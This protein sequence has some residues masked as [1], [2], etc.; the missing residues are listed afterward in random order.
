MSDDAAIPAPL[1]TK[2]PMTAKDVRVSAGT[3]GMVSLAVF[4]SRILGLVREIVFNSLFGGTMRRWG[5]A[6]TTA[7]RVP[8]LLRDLFA[9]GALSTAFVTT[10]S[11][12]LATDG[13]EAA[14][15]LARKVT[16][17]AAVFMTAV[18]IAGVVFAPWIVE[19]ISAG[20]VAK[21]PDKVDF[22]VV[23]AKIMY[24]FILLV[25]LAALAMGILNARKIF[26]V[27]AM[28]S[29][30]F[31]IF[32][33]ITGT[34]LGWCF[35]HQFGKNALIGFAIGTLIGGAAQLFVQFPALRRTGF[36][37]RPDFQ[38]KDPG[39][40]KV[41][42]LM[43]PSIISG[44]VVQFNVFLNNYYA[45]F[46]VTPDGSPDG[47]QMWLNAAFRLVQLPLGMFGVVIGTVT[48]PAISRLA[49]EGITDAFKDTLARSL[50]LVFLMTV[51]SAVGMVLLSHEIIGIIYQ[52]GRFST[53][54]TDMA[55]LGL[56]TYAW[57]L[58]CFAGIKI[59]Q[60]AFY[61]IDR[62]YIPLVISVAAV[63]VSAVANYLTVYTWHLGHQYLALGTSL[64]A[65]VNFGLLMLAMRSVAG[66]MR[67]RELG[68]N[69]AKLLVSS[70]AMAGVCWAAKHSILLNF[71]H[72]GLPLQILT[73]L[74]TIGVAAGVYFGVNALLRNEEVEDI[75]GLILRKFRR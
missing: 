18:S 69:M 32:S 42:Q 61:A 22:A 11:K 35:D 29:T 37:F 36:R 70:L 30:F 48:L 33:I 10:F 6:F 3:M 2:K 27:P 55:A 28:A 40:Q 20:W 59:V 8:N 39:V 50:K 67:G 14:W 58:I 7:F 75:K 45:S 31:N 5:D 19:A 26:G 17:M 47:P 60:P 9:E 16:T 15:R 64:S 54:D 66:G 13:E 12:T 57:G 52:H 25:S 38:W 24:P 65:F 74:V 21:Y 23:L 53:F 73:L 41:L 1:E 4:S 34:G 71:G 68:I 43:G 51:P 62:R 49:T 44:S 56:E 63:L 46:V 72:H